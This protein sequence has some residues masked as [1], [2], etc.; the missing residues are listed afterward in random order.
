M[1]SDSLRLGPLLALMV[2]GIGIRTGML[3]LAG[4]LNPHAD[5]SNYLYLAVVLNR[6]GVFSDCGTY[7]WPPG[8]AAFLAVFLDRWGVDGIFLAKLVQTAASGAIGLALMLLSGWCFGRRASVVTGVLWCVHLPLLAYT[9]YLWPETLFLATFLPALALLLSDARRRRGSPARA[10]RLIG[11]GALFGASLYFKELSL[12]LAL[13]YAFCLLIAGR[14]RGWVLG[15]QQALLLL[16]AM[17]VVVLPWTLRNAEVYGRFVPMASTLGKNVYMGVNGGTG[18]NLEYAP[19]MRALAQEA[20]QPLYRWVV[21]PDPERW[22]QS[23]AANVIDANAENVR[24]G[25]QFFLEHPGFVLRSRIMRLADF[26]TPSTFFLRHQS[27]KLYHG[28]LAETGPRRCLVLCATLMTLLVLA[29]GWA[30]LWLSMPS[31]WVRGVLLL[32]LLYLLVSGAGMNPLSRYR[33]PLEALLLVFAAG[34]LTRGGERWFSPA[35]PR[36]VTVVGWGALLCLWALNY[37]EL[38]VIWR[39]VW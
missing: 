16:L 15:C 12:Y 7:L 38:A 22:S 3:A 37:R 31:R 36:V 13:L 23:K 17:G 28:W 11:A 14:H 39:A 18:R 25:W 35:R 21:G 9:H 30:G 27:M 1:S 34:Y 19:D 4:D 5:E 26:F 10:G 20:N 2:L 33:L 6:F 8:Q 32:T 29:M 24:R